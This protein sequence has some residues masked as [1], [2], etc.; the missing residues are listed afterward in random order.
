MKKIILL[1]LSSFIINCLHAQLGIGTTT[2]NSSA[3]LDITDT[4][5]G[6]L[7]PRMTMTQRIAIISPAEGLLV[8]QVD[9]IKGFWLFD[10][11]EWKSLLNAINGQGSTSGLKNNISTKNGI[12]VAVYTSFNAYGFTKNI[13]GTPVWTTTSITGTPLGAIATDSSIV[14]YTS[15]NAYGFAFN[16][17][18]TPT[19]TTT[20]ISGTPKG[21]YSCHDHIVVA[22]T[23]GVYGFTKNV[24]GTPTWTI[25]SISGTPVGA[26]SNGT[27]VVAIYTDLA[28]YGFTKNVS[29]TPVWTITSITGTPMGAASNGKV[30]AVYTTLNA[31]G[32]T[33][34]V[35]GNPTW[36]T[37]SITGT[38]SGITPE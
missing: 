27:D 18:G 2:P 22:T 29:G 36:T 14:V 11:T 34:N 37:T 33:H 13:S 16:S 20:S 15:Q 38:P 9:D 10:G 19:W 3:A 4:A 26:V 28:A 35:S 21:V 31:Y 30:L 23:T 24:S 25:S 17:S 1:A 6:L 5:K 32:F 7:I 8:Y 12:M